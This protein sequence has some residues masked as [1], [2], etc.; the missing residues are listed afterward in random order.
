MTSFRKFIATL[1]P[2]FRIV[3]RTA[4][5]EDIVRSYEE[6]RISLTEVVKN[7]DSKVCLI[8]DM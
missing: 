3:S 5:T 1:N 7:S 8:V 4:V 2:L 6:Q